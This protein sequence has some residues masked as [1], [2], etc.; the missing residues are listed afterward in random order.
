M[1]SGC[2]SRAYPCFVLFFV[3]LS[4]SLFAVRLLSSTHNT[5]GVKVG[6]SYALNC[7]P[8]S[9]SMTLDIR[10]SPHVP[11]PEISAMLDLWCRECSSNQ[12]EARTDEELTVQ[13]NYALKGPNDLQQH[14]ITSTDRHTNPWY[15]LFYD[16][17]TDMGLS[18]EPSV[19]PAATDSR[20]LRALGIR[21]LG[22]S[23][24]AGT[25]IMLHENDEYIPKSVFLQG[26]PIYVGLI[27]RLASAGK[28]MEDNQQSPPPP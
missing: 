27:H 9:A 28:E 17:M 21:A 5:Q 22:F 3:F 12:D 1:R 6:D 25:E 11:P 26:I 16:Q 15:G 20:F 13:W 8:P 24:M 7:V 10:I 18:L 4:L 2:V 23:P 19:F 14:S